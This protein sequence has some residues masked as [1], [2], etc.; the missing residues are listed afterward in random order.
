VHVAE[1]LEGDHPIAT[2]GHFDVELGGLVEADVEGVSDLDP[3][4]GVR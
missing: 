4:R 2:D 3:V 1:E